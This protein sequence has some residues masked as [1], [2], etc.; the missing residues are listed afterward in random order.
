MEHSVFSVLW[1]LIFSVL[2]SRSSAVKSLLTSLSASAYLEMSSVCASARC[3][4]LNCS[5]RT[6]HRV[7]RTWGGGVMQQSAER[8]P[9]PL[10]SK[11]TAGSCHGNDEHS[12][13][14]I[15]S[16]NQRAV[17]FISKIPN[18]TQLALYKQEFLP[19][20]KWV[21]CNHGKG[22]PQF[23]DRSVVLQI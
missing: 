1:E 11:V 5:A 19:H 9:V 23:P 13:Q 18:K 16:K 10:C 15:P 2:L 14:P 6:S 22:W 4:L 7:Q 20:V 17:L 21:I 12:D 3:W 8:R